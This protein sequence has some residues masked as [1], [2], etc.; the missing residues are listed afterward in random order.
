MR[1]EDKE[2]L[3]AEMR[4][5]VLHGAPPPDP[6]G[7]MPPGDAD[8]PEGVFAAQDL[9]AG[10]AWR[11]EEYRM[12]GGKRIWVHACDLDTVGW[13]NAQA[14]RDL[15]GMAVAD[16]NEREL[17]RQHRA[18]VY[19]V[20]ACCRIGPEPGARR[21][22]GPE[23]AARLGRGGLPYEVIRRICLISDRLGGDEAV[24]QDGF[25]AFF[26]AA[27]T[28]AETWC[29]RATEDWPAGLSD[30]LA[31]FAGCVSRTKARGALSGQDLAT[32]QGLAGE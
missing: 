4:A 6:A 20:I 10:D 29:G 13:L 8:V 27:Q 15:A 18:M 32:M 3:L 23:H 14:L 24:L 28:W 22:F 26:D 19:Q 17:K 9:W 16:P 5:R 7:E 2:T 31:A 21:V 12:P 1:K 25:A 30:D 11:S